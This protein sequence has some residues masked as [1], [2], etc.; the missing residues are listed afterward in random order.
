ML[1]NVCI[2]LLIVFVVWS[3]IHVIVI[4]NIYL[5]SFVSILFFLCLECYSADFAKTFGYESSIHAQIAL[6]RLIISLYSTNKRFRHIGI[7]NTHMCMYLPSGEHDTSSRNVSPRCIT[8]LCCS[9][10]AHTCVQRPIFLY[11]TLHTDI[12]Y[13]RRVFCRRK[14]KMCV[15]IKIYPSPYYRRNKTT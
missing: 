11:M 4:W 8:F 14:K 2:P 13:M 9:L 5:V 15:G 3:V 10:K 6:Q 7:H 12:I 1:T